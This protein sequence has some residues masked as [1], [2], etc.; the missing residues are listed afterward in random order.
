M[1]REVDSLHAYMS[2]VLRRLHLHLHEIKAAE[3]QQYI[4]EESR[5]QAQANV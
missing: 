2:L 3:S 5:P 1:A 4:Y